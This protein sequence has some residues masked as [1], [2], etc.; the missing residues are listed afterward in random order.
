VSKDLQLQRHHHQAAA[1]CKSYWVNIISTQPDPLALIVI[2][3]FDRTRDKELVLLLSIVS[4]H[5]EE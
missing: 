3:I 1:I 4:M 2:A 5:F